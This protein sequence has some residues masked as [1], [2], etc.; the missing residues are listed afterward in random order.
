MDGLIRVQRS[1]ALPE[2]SP[3]RMEAAVRRLIEAGRL[4]GLPETEAQLRLALV[5][6]LAE[7]TAHRVRQ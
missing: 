5:V 4:L 3:E 6:L 1:A 2:A 7:S